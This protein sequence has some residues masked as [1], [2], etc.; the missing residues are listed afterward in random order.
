[1]LTEAPALSV[2]GLCVCVCVGL[3]V[4]ACEWC[5]CV[6]SWFTNG[7]AVKLVT[8]RVPNSFT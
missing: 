6:T 1:M 4:R 2:M 3:F 5:V 7:R 8:H